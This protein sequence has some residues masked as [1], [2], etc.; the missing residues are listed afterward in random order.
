MKVRAAIVTAALVM[1]GCSSLKPVPIAAGDVCFNC[2]RIINDPV[3]A[4]EV[5]EKS[6]LAFKFRTVGCMARY[7]KA[8]PE[9]VGVVY[10]TDNSTK[11]L[12]KASTATFVPTVLV[13]GYKKTPD[14]IAFGTDKEAR[15]AAAREK[16]EPRDWKAVLAAAE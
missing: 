9:N 7:L 15:E 8:H 10:V 11:R 6:G 1:A 13:E 16:S 14:Y 12:I 3:M 4:A 2:R 5:V